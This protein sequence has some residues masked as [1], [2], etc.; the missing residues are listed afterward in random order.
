MCF[1]L[2]GVPGAQLQGTS[3]HPG[4]AGLQQFLR[5]GKPEQH[6]GLHEKNPLQLKPP[7]SELSAT[8]S[9]FSNKLTERNQCLVF[10]CTPIKVKIAA[11]KM[12]DRK[13]CQQLHQFKEFYYL[14][15]S[16]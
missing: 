9:Y 10:I 5:L 7:R 14:M 6:G 11:S 12:V 3:L 13:Q 2:G 16:I 4:E 15:F 8:N 1:Q